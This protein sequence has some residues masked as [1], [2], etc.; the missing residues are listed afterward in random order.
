MFHRKL[1]ICHEHGKVLRFRA[2]V[3][4]RLPLLP[5][6]HHLRDVDMSCL[7]FG[8]NPL[9]LITACT[10]FPNLNLPHFFFFFLYPSWRKIQFLLL[11]LWI[12]AAHRHLFRSHCTRGR[13]CSVSEQTKPVLDNL[14]FSFPHSSKTLVNLGHGGECRGKCQCFVNS[15]V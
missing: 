4:P 1:G 7:S 6:C 2:G 8:F 5:F 15:E 13:E 9:T 10:F 14:L 12:R 3:P 11:L